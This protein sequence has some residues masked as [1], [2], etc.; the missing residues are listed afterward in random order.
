MHHRTRRF[1]TV[2]TKARHFSL[3]WASSIQKRSCLLNTS[4]SLKTHFNTIL[5]STPMSSNLSLLSMY[6]P[7]SPSTLSLLPT[8]STLHE[9]QILLQTIVDLPI[10]K[11]LHCRWTH[12]FNESPTRKLLVVPILLSYTIT[13]FRWTSSHILPMQLFPSAK[14]ARPTA[15]GR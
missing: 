3:S 11:S 13:R 1:I 15:I 9:A 4:Y 5:T 2:L 10:S 7:L 6:L 8:G 12:I 14:P